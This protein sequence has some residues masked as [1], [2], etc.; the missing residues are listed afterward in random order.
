LQGCP[1]RRKRCSGCGRVVGAIHDREE[2]WV[3]DLP[4]FEAETWLVIPRNR[5]ACPSC[6]SKLEALPW[7]DRFARVT[8]RLAESVARPCQVLPIKHVA[9]SLD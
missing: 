4:L 7:L 9:R 3:R 1:E 2:R 5:L 8:A 6:G